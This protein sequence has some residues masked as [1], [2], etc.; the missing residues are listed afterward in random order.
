MTRRL[1]TLLP[2][3]LAA[4]CGSDPAPGTT[5][6]GAAGVAAPVAPV[7]GATAGAPALPSTPTTGTNTGAPTTPTTGTPTT[8]TTTPTTSTPNMP[9][10]P[11]NMGTAGAG[12]NDPAACRG[13]SFENLI[14]SPGGSVLPNKCEPY[15]ATTN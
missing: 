6:L 4:A 11:T 9:T 2:F 10:T 3:L 5:G 1:M 7:P 8:P 12:A 14:Y 13:F 15:N